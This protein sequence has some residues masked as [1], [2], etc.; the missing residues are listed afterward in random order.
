MCATR[1]R[2]TH[3]HNLTSSRAQIHSAIYLQQAGNMTFHRTQVLRIV[4]FLVNILEGIVNIY[5]LLAWA[6]EY[7][8]I[9]IHKFII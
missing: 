3:Q 6:Q 9:N 1:E 2:E 4:E 8:I 5:K 7:I